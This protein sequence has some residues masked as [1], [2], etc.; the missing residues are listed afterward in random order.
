MCP[1][2]RAVGMKELPHSPPMVALTPRCVVSTSPGPQMPEHF[3]AKGTAGF[4][5]S[6][7]CGCEEGALVPCL[8]TNV[9]REGV[10]G[11]LTCHAP[12]L[13]SN[14]PA[15]GLRLLRSLWPV[16]LLAPQGFTDVQVSERPAKR[17][18]SSPPHGL[19]E[20]LLLAEAD[21]VPTTPPRANSSRL[22]SSQVPS[23]SS[24][25]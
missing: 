6:A 8:P 20:L 21:R 23:G 15:A 9:L 14:K 16:S 3:A 25:R 13:N 22:T 2:A 19:I 5:R 4:D 17:P 10:S 12:F 24:S 18:G 11:G 7:E 1:L